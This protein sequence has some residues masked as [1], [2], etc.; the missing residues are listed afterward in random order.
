MQ[1][2]RTTLARWLSNAGYE[3]IEPMEFYRHMF[4]A[5]ELAEYTTT[6]RAEAANQE[7]KYN[8]ILL[9]NTH[10]T[11]KVRKKDPRS[12]EIHLTEKEVW[13]NYI[14]T[15]DLSRIEQA[16][17]QYG[18]TDSEFYIAPLSYLGRKRTKA[19]ERW[20]YACIVEVDHPKTE[21]V[22]DE[23]P[24]TGNITKHRVQRGMNQ[25]IHD[26]TE[27][28]MPYAMPSACVCSGSG[29]HLIYFLDRPY[30]IQDEYQ[31]QQWDNFRVKFTQR[32]WNKY[33]TKAAIQYE[34]HCQSFR[35]VGTRTKKGQVVEAFW[36]SKKRYTLEELFS[37][38]PYD[39][40]PKWM[41]KWKTPEEAFKVIDHRKMNE[42]N[43]LLHK[44]NQLMLVEKG[45]MPKLAQE[46]SPK[47]LAAQEQWPDWYQRRVIEHQPP[48]Q[49]G[50]W[51][52]G[53]GVYDW[54]LREAK[55]NPYVGSRFHR[56]HALAE[57]A[58][59]CGIS[60][61]EFKKDAYELYISFKKLD[62]IEP[63]HYQEYVKARDEYFSTISHKST[64]DWI[65][66]SSGIHMNPP[67][68]RNGRSRQEH[69]QT[70]TLVNKETGRPMINSCKANRDMTLQYMRENGEI[71]GRPKKQAQVEEWQ[72]ANPGGTKMEC[73]KATG[74]SRPTIDKWW[75]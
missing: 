64:R 59:K 73:H 36:L 39:R 54:F 67:A 53:R 9:E 45:S 42:Y 22:E 31:K 5:G 13:K 47:M 48:K 55:E 63:F 14:V 3:T 57:F 68:K 15:D 44:P 52:V 75:K 20:I 10:K 43:N 30:Q 24:V 71:T 2:K 21:M 41:G 33:V 72:A 51:T 38:V 28:S 18:E 7:W 35:V 17:N 29:L 32:V 70:P 16:V 25:L 37:Q 61:D 27:S 26:W 23:Y 56:V 46:P 50:Q 12:G 34:N 11:R 49:P 69:L 19:N 74:I 58:V 6:P 4:P 62:D 66:R 40:L 1:E 8:A 60:Y 65:D